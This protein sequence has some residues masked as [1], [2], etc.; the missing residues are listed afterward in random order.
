M[1]LRANA[2]TQIVPLCTHSAAVAIRIVGLVMLGGLFKPKYQI[3]FYS[4]ICRLEERGEKG[5]KPGDLARLRDEKGKHY[6]L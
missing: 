2:H 5:R 3:Q 4:Q 1:P 6:L